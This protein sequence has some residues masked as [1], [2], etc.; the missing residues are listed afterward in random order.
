[1]RATFLSQI[2]ALLA[3]TVAD[4]GT[5]VAPADSRVILTPMFLE[6]RISLDGNAV[7]LVVP[8]V[9]IKISREKP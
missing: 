7:C 9:A 4:D 3:F 6:L 5:L 1:M 8:R 2:D